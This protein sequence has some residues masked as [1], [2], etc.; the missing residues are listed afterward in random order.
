MLIR[1]LVV[2]LTLVGSMPLRVCTCGADHTAARTDSDAPAPQTCPC[3]SAPAPDA[4]AHAPRGP[5]SH[6]H[7]HDCPAA[8]PRPLVRNVTAPTVTVPD[9]PGDCGPAF[10][11]VAAVES[12]PVARDSSVERI[13]PPPKVP[14]Y[15]AYLSLR[16]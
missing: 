8:H 7:D 14:L 5:E 3:K 10:A 9:A 6:H 15:L 4:H 16:N 1:V 12:A 13:E 11:F 2:L